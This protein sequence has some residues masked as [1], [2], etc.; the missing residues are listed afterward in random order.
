[1][2]ATTLAETRSAAA[3]GHRTGVTP[4]PGAAVDCLLIALAAVAIAAVLRPFQNTPF[5]D[6]W[7]YGWP[8]Q[9]LLETGEL[10]IPEYSGNPIVTQIFWGVAFSLPF[11]FS[12]TALRISTWTLAVAVLWAVYLLLRDFGASRQTARLGAALMGVYPIFFVLSPTFMT[13]VPFLALLV[14][15]VLLFTRALDRRQPRLVWMASLLCCVSVGI[16]SQGVGIVGALFMTLLLHTGRWGRRP[17]LLIAPLLVLPVAGTL[18]AWLPSHTL[19]SADLT[20][21]GN[22]P[23]NRIRDL[24]EYA[25]PILPKML[26]VTLMFVTTALGVALLPLVLGVFRWR[27]VGRAALLVAAL[28]AIWVTGTY[29]GIGFWVPLKPGETW[30]LAELGATASLVPE[31]RGI[32]PFPPWA[33]WIT[34]GIGLALASVLLANFPFCRFTEREKC[35]VWVM[36][37][38]CALAAMLWLFY[39]RYSLVYL[40]LA[41]VLCLARQPSLRLRPA[42]AGV[43]LYGAVSMI[44]TRDHLAYNAAVWS[45]VAELQA[46]GVPAAELNGG[47]VVNGW[48]QYVR[49]EQAHRSPEGR[50][51][52]PWVNEQ[53]ELPYTVANGPRRDAQVLKTIPYVCWLRPSGAVY[54]LKRWCS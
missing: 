51:E 37:G 21:I 18:L 22:A 2:T 32:L 30:A 48:L 35:I 14:W 54:V 41:I 27:T 1:M 11:G 46:Q 28:S 15:S 31:Y 19:V 44:G 36:A 3:A 40:P 23:A 42:W 12:F 5:I 10:R 20:W 7:V 16:R 24:R 13:D 47:Y 33:G 9:H 43:M 26:V 39:D 8:V 50:I 49:P 25:L 52:I 38:Q 17:H 45:A 6:D 29:G 34:T 4:I 53:L